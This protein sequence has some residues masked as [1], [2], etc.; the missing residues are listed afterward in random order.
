VQQDTRWD[1]LLPSADAT[2]H[3]LALQLQNNLD[4][5]AASGKDDT[6]LYFFRLVLAHEDMHHEA[7]LYMAQALGL[8]IADARW[9]PQSL[10]APT[11]PLRFEAA[12]FE[13]GHPVGEGFVFDN[14][15]GT[16][17]VS[18]PAFEIDS[19]VLCWR[20]Y[21]PFVDATQAPAPRYLR[22]ASSSATGWQF[23][24]YGQWQDLD[25]ALPVC[26]V[27]AREAQA[28][29]QWAGRRLPT[30]AEW[31]R[32]ATERPQAFQWGAVWEWTAS[33]FEPYPGFEPHPYREYSAPWFGGSHRV[34]RGACFATQ[35]RLRNRR[36]RNFF[37][38]ERNDVFA[39]FRSCAL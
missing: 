2:R 28:W 13:M 23:Q 21:L 25:L 17:G 31:E 10:P 27:N 16:H 3:D 26:H 5:L 36:Y 20:G 11:P 37:T 32:A 18:V 14:E 35:P 6:A 8:P 38:P 19:Q 24:R 30:E 12:R 22:R 39:G 1:L 9:Q 15:R 33:D 4:L 7:A 29:C 34:L